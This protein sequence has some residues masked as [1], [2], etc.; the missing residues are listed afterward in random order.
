MLDGQHYFPHTRLEQFE[1]RVLT[2]HCSTGVVD[3][4]D[5][6]PLIDTTV[7]EGSLIL[8]HLLD[9]DSTLVG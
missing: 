4:K 9:I 3:G 8:D 1:D 7:E 5:L 2:S 6:V